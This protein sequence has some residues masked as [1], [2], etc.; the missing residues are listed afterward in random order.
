MMNNEHTGE[1][2]IFDKSWLEPPRFYHDGD[3][4]GCRSFPE[5]WENVKFRRIDYFLQ[6]TPKR[7]LEVGCGS[8]GVSLYLY[9]K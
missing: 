8:G 9:N 1:Y 4:S 6:H 2:E 3:V 7:V 5:L